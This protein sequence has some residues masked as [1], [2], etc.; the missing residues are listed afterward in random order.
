ME[1]QSGLPQGSLGYIPDSPPRPLNNTAVTMNNIKVEGSTIGVLNTGTI[2]TVDSAVTVL[3][4]AGRQDAAS[5]LTTV[6]EA[7][8]KSD[9][10]V[11]ENKNQLLSSSASSQLSHC[12]QRRSTRPAMRA[13]LSQISSLVSAPSAVAEL[14]HKSEGLIKSFFGS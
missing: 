3:Q 4:K 13:I 1:N 12:R 7:I 8:I 10:I 14:W 2:Q 6:T 5:A 11:A 9:Q